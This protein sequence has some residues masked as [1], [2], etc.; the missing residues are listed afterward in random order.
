[1]KAFKGRIANGE[2]LCLPCV[3]WIVAVFQR[4]KVGG[5]QCGS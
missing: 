5:V 2:W 4:R 1:M 3:R